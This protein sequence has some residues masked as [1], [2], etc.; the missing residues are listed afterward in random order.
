MKIFLDTS[1][2]I[3]LY[4]RESGTEILEQAFQQLSITT[5]FLSEISK[6]EF[7]STIW[8]KVRTA[9]I[10]IEQAKKTINLFEEDY[11]K[12]TFISAD[13]AIIESANKLLEKYG[14]QGLRTLDSIQLSSCVSLS[15]A[16]TIFITA[17]KLLKLFLAEEGLQTEIG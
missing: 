9:E 14:G 15:S 3:K 4:H 7:S 13:S 11:G 2:L 1:S 17:D 12:F 16:D 6:L 5:V 10:S 8:K